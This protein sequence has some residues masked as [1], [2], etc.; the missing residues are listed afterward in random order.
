LTE[1]EEFLKHVNGSPYGFGFPPITS[2]QNQNVIDRN[3]LLLH[4]VVLWWLAS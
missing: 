3:V 2:H 1:L 4:L